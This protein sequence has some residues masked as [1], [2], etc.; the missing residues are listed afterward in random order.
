M[1][2][3]LIYLL[4]VALGVYAVYEIFTKKTATEMTTKV[5]SALLILLTSWVGIAVYY[6]YLRDKL[7]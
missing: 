2:S 6:F 1:I 5:L 4:G 7:K 3:T